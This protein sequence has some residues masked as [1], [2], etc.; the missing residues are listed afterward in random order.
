MDKGGAPV[1]NTNAQ[2]GRRFYRILEGVSAE[3]GHK[4]LIAAAHAL[5]DKGAA[6]DLRAIE[7]LRDTLDGK[8]KQVSELDEPTRDLVRTLVAKFHASGTSD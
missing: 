5:L 4:R 3:E 2:K 6:G 7:T 1:G 8:P